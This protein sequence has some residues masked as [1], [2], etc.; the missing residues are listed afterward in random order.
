LIG[1]KALAGFSFFSKK[2]LS[3]R[4]TQNLSNGSNGSNKIKKV[5]IND[6]NHDFDLKS[7]LILCD[8]V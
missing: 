2:K 4:T 8:N 3:P 5:Y 6:L 7:G 1:E